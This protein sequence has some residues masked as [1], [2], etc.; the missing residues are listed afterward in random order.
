MP[1]LYVNKKYHCDMVEVQDHFCMI[2]VLFQSPSPDTKFKNPDKNFARF[3]ISSFLD[4][5]I[6]PAVYMDAE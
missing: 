4:H 5:V 6:I 3:S 1:E 2:Q